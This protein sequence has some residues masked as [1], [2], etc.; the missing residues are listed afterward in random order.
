MENGQ[1]NYL[2]FKNKK[3]LIQQNIKLRN[4]VL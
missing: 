4:Q 2:N 3:R 1:A